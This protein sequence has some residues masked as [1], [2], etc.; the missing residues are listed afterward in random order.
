MYSVHTFAEGIICFE[1]GCERL[2]KGV[3]MFISAGVSFGRAYVKTRTIRDHRFDC[4][5]LKVILTISYRAVLKVIL[6]ISSL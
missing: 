4:Q 2:M 1:I 5:H 3:R 6:T